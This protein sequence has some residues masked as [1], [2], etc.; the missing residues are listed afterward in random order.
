MSPAREEAAAARRAVRAAACQVTICELGMAG[1]GFDAD[2]L[3]RF[4]RDLDETA[5]RLAKAAEAERTEKA[6]DAGRLA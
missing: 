6:M 1:E 4:E 2:A 5:A 3:R